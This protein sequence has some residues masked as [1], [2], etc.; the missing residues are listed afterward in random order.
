MTETETISGI[1]DDTRPN[2]ERIYDYFLGGNHNFEIDRLAAAKILEYVPLMPKICRLIRWFLGEAARTLTEKG[3]TQFI[4]FASG[5]PVQDHIHSIV[6]PGTKVLYSDNDPV[7]VAYAVELLGNTPNVLY[8]TCDVLDPLQILETAAAV[9]FL[10]RSKK[11]AF[12]LNGITYFM[13]DEQLRYTLSVLYDWAKE[14]D[15]LYLCDTSIH[16]YDSKDD[17]TDIYAKMGNPLYWHNEE[18]MSRLA[19]KWRPIPPGFQ[20]LETWLRIEGTP[21]SVTEEEKATYNGNFYGVIFEK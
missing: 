21:I 10:D 17:A 9:S 2:M 18:N 5:L 7:T 8:M 13:K 19:G 11:T 20:T 12:G 14:G 16:D 4:D 1:A 15:M 6:P 3:V